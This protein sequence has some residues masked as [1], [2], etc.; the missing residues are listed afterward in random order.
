M[1]DSFVNMN[2]VEGKYM[3]NRPL[4]RVLLLHQHNF[5]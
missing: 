2:R 5:V 3:G 4:G 1:S